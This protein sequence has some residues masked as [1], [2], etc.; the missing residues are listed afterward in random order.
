MTI[1]STFNGGFEKDYL[2]IYLTVKFGVSKYCLISNFHKNMISLI[3][4]TS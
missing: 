1:F 3:S 2:Y 4:K